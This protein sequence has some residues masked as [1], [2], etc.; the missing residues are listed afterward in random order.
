MNAVWRARGIELNKGFALVVHVQIQEGK[1]AIISV[2]LEG[3]C[4]QHCSIPDGASAHGSGVSGDPKGS[5]SKRTE[6]SNPSG[7]SC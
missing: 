4:C 6:I 1:I 5:V 3:W 2:G 7:I